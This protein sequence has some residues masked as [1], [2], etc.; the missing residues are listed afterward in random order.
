[1]S[2]SGNASLSIQHRPVSLSV[3]SSLLVALAAL[4]LLIGCNASVPDPG[5]NDAGDDPSTEG[6]DEALTWDGAAVEGVFFASTEDLDADDAETAV[7]DHAFLSGV[8]R[9][10]ATEVWGL[11]SAIAPIGQAY[12][13]DLDGEVAAYVALFASSTPE[14]SAQRA[15]DASSTPNPPKAS[16]GQ[17]E[18]VAQWTATIQDL[19]NTTGSAFTE[20]YDTGAYS[21]AVQA[22]TA[23]GRSGS[24]LT[25]VAGARP[26]MPQIITSNLGL[27]PMIY[28]LL[29]RKM[30]ALDLGI[31]P[32]SVT[33]VR[34][35]CEPFA[36][37]GNRFGVICRV[38]TDADPQSQDED[39][40]Q[41]VG[42]VTDYIYILPS[43][44]YPLGTVTT[45]GTYSDQLA[46]IEAESQT[47]SEASARQV[48]G[49][50]DFA[51][52]WGASA[53]LLGYT[54]I[55]EVCD[56]CQDDAARQSFDEGQADY[57]TDV[58]AKQDY[59]GTLCYCNEY[60]SD[61]TSEP[62]TSCPYENEACCDPTD[63]A[64]WDQMH[65]TECVCEC[66][67]TYEYTETHGVYLR[68]VPIFY[69]VYVGETIC[70]AVNGT[71]TLSGCG[72][73]AGAMFLAWYDMMGYTEL[74]DDWRY[75]QTGSRLDWPD[76]AAELRKD[77]YMQGFC[78]LTSAN[79][80]G[81]AGTTVLTGNCLMGLHKY[82]TEKG[83]DAWLE[84]VAVNSD[85]EMDT[86]YERIKQE[87]DA[88]RPI[89]IFYCASDE[90]CND[91]GIDGIKGGHVALIT[92]YYEDAAG[93]PGLVINPGWGAYSD[94]TM[95]WYLS[96]GKI[97]LGYI[98]LTEPPTHDANCGCDDIPTYFMD[99]NNDVGYTMQNASQRPIFYTGTEVVTETLVGT[100][101]AVVEDQETHTGTSNYTETRTCPSLD[102]LDGQEDT[103]GQIE[104]AC[105][106]HGYI[107][108]C[109]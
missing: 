71:G 38:R 62:V 106:E 45:K 102:D 59:D 98:E 81:L 58:I 104:E 1:M 68:G 30:I 14:D 73:T 108:G 57:V 26:T 31:S 79:S 25:V 16:A 72:P 105:V 20:A 80:N 17:R 101:C 67:S 6:Q 41:L 51:G 92:G 28:R 74:G 93:A 29:A 76:L 48:A 23:L 53:A 90:H 99:P 94:R 11:D 56:D 7:F 44:A 91:I 19:L 18:S 15:V 100:A 43:I 35:F 21:Q 103:T 40:A 47:T 27:P 84:Q 97:W 70:N 37:F 34:T 46:A 87:I 78:S 61:G 60:F 9:R 85:E 2:C 49:T 10:H 65:L 95:S 77:K 12:L 82:I 69:Q 36:P 42:G 109:E 13:R 24:F 8:A 75:P 33:P 63:T 39:A 22:M 4:S 55:D 3:A 64:C 83:I 88:H 89:I 66:N 50:A 52:A 96:D 107:E 32:L 86:A 5:G 54:S